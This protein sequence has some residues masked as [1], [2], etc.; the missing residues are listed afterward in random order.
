MDNTTNDLYDISTQL[1]QLKKQLI[2]QSKI[3]DIALTGAKKKKN[4]KI[5]ELNQFYTN[6]RNDQFIKDCYISLINPFN[7]FIKTNIN[8]QTIYDVELIDKILLHLS[9]IIE[10]HKNALLNANDHISDDNYDLVKSFNIDKI[11]KIYNALN[12]RLI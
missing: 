11:I 5:Y 12:N 8:K 4:L 9:L 10:T 7:H 1:Y 3:A 6:Y 2:N